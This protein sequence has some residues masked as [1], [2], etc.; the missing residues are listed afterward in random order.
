[1]NREDD[2]IKNK[3]VLILYF[4]SDLENTFKE[5]SINLHPTQDLMNRAYKVNVSTYFALHTVPQILCIYSRFSRHSTA[6][7]SSV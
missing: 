1:M 3:K 5:F 4:R 6:R 7:G 2:K